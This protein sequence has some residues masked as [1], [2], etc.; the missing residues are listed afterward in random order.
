MFLNENSAYKMYTVQKEEKT[1]A[2]T[3]YPYYSL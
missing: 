3:F 1:K 2:Y